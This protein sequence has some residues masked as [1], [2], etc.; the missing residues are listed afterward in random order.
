MKERE[1]MRISIG[2]DHRG[3]ALKNFIINYFKEYQW[4]DVGTN[5]QE[6]IDYPPFAQK[7]CR[8]VLEGRADCGIVICGSGIGVSI[9]A[10]RFKGIYAALCWD[11]EVARH[12]R[13]YDGANVLALPANFVEPELTIDIVNAWTGAEFKGG[14]YQK[15]LDM[16][17]DIK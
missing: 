3:F 11:P 10:N 15:R 12:A 8:D 9:A 7:V 2:A 1:R 16:I 5:S 6:R 4:I 17:E 14:I 13:E